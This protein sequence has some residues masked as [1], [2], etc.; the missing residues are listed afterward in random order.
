MN[1]GRRQANRTEANLPGFDFVST[2]NYDAVW[3]E[4]RE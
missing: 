2:L 4:K 1:H 3:G